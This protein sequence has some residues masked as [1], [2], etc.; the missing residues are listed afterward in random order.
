[1]AHANFDVIEA[2]EAFAAKRSLTMA[3]IAIGGLAALPTVGS[4]I[5]GATSPDQVRENAAAGMWVPSGDD[6]DELLTIT[7]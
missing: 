7:G 4:V 5:A 2:V 1:V 6:L 3:Q